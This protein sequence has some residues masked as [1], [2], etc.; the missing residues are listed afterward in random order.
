MSLANC[1]WLN[2]ATNSPTLIFPFFHRSV[3]DMLNL[4]DFREEQQW[5]I[6]KKSLIPGNGSELWIQMESSIIKV[7]SLWTLAKAL[8]N[9]E[10]PR[11]ELN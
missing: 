7:S 4:V 11:G 3:F 6:L 5:E 1:K 2:V 9:L 8:V 10:L